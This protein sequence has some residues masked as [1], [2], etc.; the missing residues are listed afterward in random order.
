MS[1]FDGKDIEFKYI[2]EPAIQVQ[3]LLNQWKHEYDME[4]IACEFVN[5]V[6]V[7]GHGPLNYISM[8]MARRR[9]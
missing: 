7:G 6:M 3:K 2:S 1:I 8:L 4:I 5:N 9:R